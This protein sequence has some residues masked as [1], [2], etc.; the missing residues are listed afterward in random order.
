MAPV[1]N[2]FNFPESCAVDLRIGKAL[3]ADNGPL[4]PADRRV[5]RNEV[6]EILCSYV[7]DETHGIMLSPY[8]DE[9]H[10][11]TCLAQVDVFL[12]KP[13]KALRVAE[14]CHR[15]M[16]YPLI[17]VLHDGETLMFSM[18]EKRFSRDGKGQVVLERSVCT[19]WTQTDRLADFRNAADFGRNRKLG[20][21]N[22]HR[23]YIALLDVQQC[24]E[25]TGDFRETG[26][27]PEERRTLL[28]DLHRLNQQLAEVK[29]AAKKE[30]ELSKQVELNMR[31]QRLTRDIRDIREK[32]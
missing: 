11:Y 17:V 15:A 6:E 3:F 1:G 10:D 7:L 24:A 26:L 19:A 12:K 21:R 9:E 29:A 30:T 27:T 4:T 23:H 32:M 13:G 5:F 8:S 28:D 18:A 31:A 22:L 14:L 25:I 20:F 2:I 16:P